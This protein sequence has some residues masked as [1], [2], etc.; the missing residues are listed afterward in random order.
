MSALHANRPTSLRGTT[1]LVR[2]SPALRYV[3]TV[4]S[5]L[6]RSA[7]RLAA[8]PP[9]AQILPLG[10]GLASY[11]RPAGGVPIGRVFRSED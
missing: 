5:A 4:G 1:E 6:P 2:G 3:R 9:Q 11:P 10:G 7:F 8:P